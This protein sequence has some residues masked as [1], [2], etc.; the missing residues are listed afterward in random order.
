MAAPV[1]AAAGCPPALSPT[2]LPVR[3]PHARGD[4]H[5][6]APVVLSMAPASEALPDQWT[7]NLTTV[8][9]TLSALKAGTDTMTTPDTDTTPGD[10]GVVPGSPPPYGKPSPDEPPPT[11]RSLREAAH[12]NHGAPVNRAGFFSR[13]LTV[14]AFRSHR[15]QPA[16]K[17]PVGVVGEL[18]RAASVHG[19]HTLQRR[20]IP[21]QRGRVD[22][23][24]ISGS[25]VYVIDIK[26]HKNAPVELRQPQAEGG[27]APQLIVGGRD[28][29]TAA[30]ATAR[31]VAVVRAALDAAGHDNVPVTGALCF[32]DG[33]LPLGV[34]ELHTRGVH[35]LRHSALTALVCAAGALKPADRMA[36][37][38]YLSEHFPHAG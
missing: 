11:R 15:S 33:L 12:Q 3:Q 4:R 31:R 34:A 8:A 29:T 27:T 36:L 5:P 26:H 2:G 18:L 38:D 25:G 7:A 17:G 9:A 13:I 28:M 30:T 37:K 16:G 14:R 32:V 21:G 23:F 19:V 1:G 6:P 24:A 35:V 20:R 22:Y 10:E